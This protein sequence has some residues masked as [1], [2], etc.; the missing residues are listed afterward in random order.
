MTK[1]VPISCSKSSGMKLPVFFAAVRFSGKHPKPLTIPTF[2]RLDR[3]GFSKPVCAILPVV[4]GMITHHGWSFSHHEREVRVRDCLA[5][6]RAILAGIGFADAKTVLSA[7]E[8][9]KAVLELALV[10]RE[11]ADQTTEMIV[12]AVA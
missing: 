5:V 2:S 10:R 12:M 4:K 6:E 8:E 7:N 11:E 9:R 3:S 1:F